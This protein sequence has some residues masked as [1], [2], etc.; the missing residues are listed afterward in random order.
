MAL[1]AQLSKMPLRLINV[2]AS[3]PSNGIGTPLRTGP[4]PFPAEN[5]L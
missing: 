2:A 5:I 3:L 4:P 1:L